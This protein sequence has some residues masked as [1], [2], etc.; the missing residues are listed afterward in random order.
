MHAWKLI[1]AILCV[2]PGITLPSQEEL[3]VVK[4]FLSERPEEKNKLGIL[5]KF[6]AAFK[7]SYELLAAVETFGCS[8]AVCESTFSTLT[9]INRP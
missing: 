9:S 4:K 2:F 1:L 6:R 7:E 3:A 8:T 5:Y